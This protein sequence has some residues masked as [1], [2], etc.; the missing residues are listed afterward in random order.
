MTERE[1]LIKLLKK[2]DELKCPYPDKST[3]ECFGCE[4]NVEGEEYCDHL[5]YAD[6]LLANGVI[7]PPCKVGDTAYFVLY[8]G[9]VDEWFISE[10]PIVDV[11]TKGFYTSGKK[12]STENCD[13]WLWSCVGNDT[14]FDKEAAEEALKGGAE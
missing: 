5:R 7:V 4:Y 9:V 10:E 11:C 6:Y 13:L 1:R 12:D 2:T 14:F 3:N 8:D